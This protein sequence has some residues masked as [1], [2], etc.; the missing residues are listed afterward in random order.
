M[1]SLPRY[2]TSDEHTKAQYRIAEY[3][4]PMYMQVFVEYDVPTPNVSFGVMPSIHTTKPYRLDVYAT[5]PRPLSPYFC[6]YPILGVEIDGK[7]GHSSDRQSVRD[8]RRTKDIEDF[9]NM[10]IHRFHYKDIIGRN[11]LRLA[12]IYDELGISRKGV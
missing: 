6:Q 9:Y 11:T 3:L 8:R 5:E 1:S 12:L 10:S 4:K 2:G 7:Y